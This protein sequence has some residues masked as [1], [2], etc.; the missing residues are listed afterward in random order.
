M[1]SL[2]VLGFIFRSAAQINFEFGADPHSK[3]KG[4][5]LIG[6]GSTIPSGLCSQ[7]NGMS[8]FYPFLNTELITIPRLCQYF[9]ISLSLK[10][11]ELERRLYQ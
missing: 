1:K 2:T 5:I 4:D 9:A 10:F 6:I 7:A 3:L 8:F 11:G